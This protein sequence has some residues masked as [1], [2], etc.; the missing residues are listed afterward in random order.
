[1]R[2]ARAS[3]IPPEL[4]PN[5]HLPRVARLTQAGRDGAARAV[6]AARC[7]EQLQQAG[8]RGA[9][10]IVARPEIDDARAQTSRRTARIA[11]GDLARIVRAGAMGA[12]RSVRSRARCEAAAA[13]TSVRVVTGDRG[14]PR[15]VI[16]PKIDHGAA[17][18]RATPQ[19]TR[20]AVDSLAE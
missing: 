18:T 20:T 17:L 2:R 6:G 19:W 5:R 11:A 3:S 9:P 1:M 4:A 16:R 15:A 12:A 8:Y 10:R 14:E 7:G 13:A